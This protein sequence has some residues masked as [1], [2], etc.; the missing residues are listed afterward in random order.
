VCQSEALINVAP[1]E[2]FRRQLTLAGTHS[3]NRNIETSL[4]FIL[5]LGSKLDPIISHQVTLGEI[6]EILDGRMPADSLKV[7]WSN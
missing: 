3:L 5:A 1:F 4:K 6:Q 7:Q 2:I